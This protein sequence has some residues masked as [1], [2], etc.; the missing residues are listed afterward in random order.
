MT[1]PDIA[2]IKQDLVAHAANQA[3]DRELFYCNLIRILLCHVSPEDLQNACDAA[4][5][6]ISF[7]HSYYEA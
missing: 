4:L 1:F 5:D 7:K 6:G 2:L 3:R